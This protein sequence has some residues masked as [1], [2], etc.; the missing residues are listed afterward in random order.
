MLI[1]AA[2]FYFTGTYYN[3]EYM[4]CSHA[5]QLPEDHQC[6][7]PLDGGGSGGGQGG[8]SGGGQGGGSGGGQGG[9]SGGGSGSGSGGGNGTQVMCESAGFYPNEDDCTKFYRCVD[10]EETGEHY[11][12][13]HFDCGP[14]NL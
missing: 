10:F 6:Y 5:W 1:M 7:K 12:I 2:I 4:T 3:P 8:G 11:T 13:F 14:G 9:G